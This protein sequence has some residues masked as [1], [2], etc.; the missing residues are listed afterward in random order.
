MK[1]YR[2]ATLKELRSIRKKAEKYFN[3][4]GQLTDEN[5]N[6][7]IA[8]NTFRSYVNFKLPPSRIYREWASKKAFKKHFLKKMCNIRCYQEFFDVHR[9]LQKSLDRLWQERQ[10]KSLTVAQCNKIIDLYVKFI[11]KNNVSELP[12]LNK[13]LIKFGHVPLDKFALIAVRKCFYGVV[14]SPN[15]SM[16]DI[17]DLETYYFIQSQIRELMSVVHIPNLFFDFYAWNLKH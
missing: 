1:L 8:G 15:P 7:G 10:G 3:D 2:K 13:P 4:R 9:K 17:D 12:D 11:S 6:W 16:G 14:I 5:T